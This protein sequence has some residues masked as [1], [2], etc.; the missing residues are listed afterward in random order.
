MFTSLIF[1]ESSFNFTHAT[2][3]RTNAQSAILISLVLGNKNFLNILY[4]I[5][6]KV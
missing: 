2:I 4:A 5:N 6:V 1:R 3:L